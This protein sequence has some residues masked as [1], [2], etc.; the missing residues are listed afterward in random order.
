M[1]ELPD[2]EVVVLSG[3]VSDKKDPF[4]NRPGTAVISDSTY[5][6]VTGV[7]WPPYIPPD[8]GST[9]TV[10]GTVS[11]YNGKAQVTVNEKETGIPKSEHCRIVAFLRDC[12]DAETQANLSYREN[13]RSF[14]LLAGA[15]VDIDNPYGIIVPNDSAGRKWLN[16]RKHTLSETLLVGLGLVVKRDEKT[17]SWVPLFT[18]EIFLDSQ[19]NSYRASALWST[20]ELNRS[21]LSELLIDD[22]Q[23]EMVLQSTRSDPDLEEATDGSA[24]L[25]RL[26]QI[27]CENDAISQDEANSISLDVLVKPVQGKR[28]NNSAVLIASASTATYTAK[29][30]DELNSIARSNSNFMSGPLAVLFG[31]RDAEPIPLPSAFPIVVP[32]SVRQDQAITSAMVNPLTVITGPPGT[33]KSQILVNLIT[34]CLSRNQS[35]LFAS[36]TNQA[37]DVVY[38]RIQAIS[39]ES[40]VLRAGP[41]SMR[42]EL[43]RSIEKALVSPVVSPDAS[44]SAQ[45]Q[46]ELINQA[47]R[48]YATLSEIHVAEK[49]LIEARNWVDK[50]FSFFPSSF[51]KNIDIKRSDQSIRNVV[52]ALNNLKRPLP[53][54]RR[55]KRATILD[56]RIESLDAACEQLTMILGLP[57]Q[58]TL[59][60]AFQS[61]KDIETTARWR[62]QAS[63]DVRNLKQLQVQI[64]KIVDLERALAKFELSAIENSIQ[65]LNTP[66]VE[67]GRR[68]SALVAQRRLQADQGAVVNARTLLGHIS[69]AADGGVGALAA[70]KELPGALPV[71]PAWG[72][73]N[74]SVGV[75]F[76]LQHQLFD[77][78]IIDEASQ[79]DLASAIPLLY[80]AKRAVIIGDP[81]QLT[82]ITSIGPARE[83]LIAE[84]YGL[85]EDQQINL[86]YRA[87][88]LYLAAERVFGE[89]IFLNLHFRSHP[90]IIQ[91]SNQNV[92]G[93]R[94]EICTKTR[95]GPDKAIQWIDVSGDCTR[96]PGRGSWFNQLEAKEVVDT[97]RRLIENDCVDIGVVTPYRAQAEKIISLLSEDPKLVNFR[98]P[99]AT[100]HRYQGSESEHIIFSPVVGPSIPSP[101]LRFASDSN[102]LNVALTRARASL[103]IVGNS[104]TCQAAGGLLS[105]LVSYVN[106][107]E[108]SDF[109]SPLELRLY[110]ALL[111]EGIEVL[112]RHQVAGHRCDLAIMRGNV[113]LD[114]E[115][116]GQAFHRD[117]ARDMSRD[118]SLRALG[119][120][121]I[122]FSGR[123]ISRDVKYCVNLIK[124]ELE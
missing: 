17:P 44:D 25:N 122:R 32:S 45:S 123:E 117:L 16:E 10:H 105:A 5:G 84:R 48:I 9:V 70:R 103:T 124:A 71:L 118:D 43:A 42:S 82:H 121:V 30:Q 35:V 7:W 64:Q 40:G 19:P 52:D 115:C 107:V 81:R 27:L 106:S 119:W 85:T 113:Q 101:S 67:A 72:V 18:A 69:S 13:R 3:R 99:V 53:W 34:A 87:Q 80:R 60:S 39:P 41:A 120:K 102:L 37:V 33:G 86:S 4:G 58:D 89:P 65:E 76:P 36:K 116:D 78:V 14:L 21:A 15:S 54:F 96:Q 59:E 75:T 73:T 57:D 68:T 90:A 61:L 56:G 100:A 104:N 11:Y 38:E 92:Y 66:R 112:P 91:F 77:L 31:T 24:K 23:I 51:N 22:S 46:F 109:D 63:A 12:A 1:Q 55:W 50:T 110:E 74:L 62:R 95:I 83:K 98:I 88:S 47:N 26:L 97:I 114:I 2:G 94:L 20:L 49:K 29:M 28:I 8:V 79:C 111:S 93:N 108:E 6:S